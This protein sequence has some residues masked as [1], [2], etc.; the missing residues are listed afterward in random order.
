MSSSTRTDARGDGRSPDTAELR[1]V[2]TAGHV[3]HGKSSLIVALTGI[4][5]DRWD[6]EKRRGLTIDLGYAW[7]TLPSGREIGFVDVPG[8]ERFIT[9]MLAGVGPVPSVLFVVAADEGWKPQSEEHLQI[10]DVLGVRAGV[11]AL[12]KADLVDAGAVTA[13]AGRVREHLAGTTLADAPIVPVAS[14]TGTGVGDIKRALDRMLE[15]VPTPEPARTRLFVDRV[16]TIK[17]SGTVVTG[18]LSGGPLSIG[19]DVAL[20]PGDTRARIRALQTHER[21]HARAFP[22]A[23]VAAN[24]AGIERDQVARGDVLTKPGVW[25]PTAMFDTVVR[26]VRGLTHPISARGAYKVYAG[27]AEADARIRFLEPAGSLAPDEEAFV[28]IRTSRPLVLDVFDRLVIR[29]AGRQETVAGGIVLDV[30]PPRRAGADRVS[31]LRARASAVRDELPGLLAAE[32]GAVSAAAAER[33][34]G[35]KAE[36]GTV[37]GTWFLRAGLPDAIEQDLGTFLAEHHRDH[38]LDEGV[39]LHRAR[40]LVGRSLRAAGALPDPELVDELLRLFNERGSILSSASTV[41]TA[42]HRVALEDH[43]DLDRLLAAIGGEREATPPTIK[44]LGAEGFGRDVI[45]AA[46]REGLVVKISPELIVTPASF[47]MAQALVTAARD[48]ITVSAFREGL[49]TS[50]KY[51]V[52]ML[53]HLDRIGVTRRDGDLRFPR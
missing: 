38:P 8:H 16:F 2:A 48:G 9:N 30:M 19:E 37:V 21:A 29:D 24:L 17:G 44:E 31:Q 53:E 41:R 3:D 10:L 1:V 49:G 11:V 18:T 14:T 45:D 12:T 22:V 52:P 23:R 25:D 50:R 32:R 51:A 27:A 46:A 26:P 34:T 35:S 7:C 33:A 20:E 5:P 6:E 40:G 43:G 47:E 15:T 4:D 39:D 42:G 13:A 28:R 36:G